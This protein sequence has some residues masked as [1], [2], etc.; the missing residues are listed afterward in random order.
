MRILMTGA[1]GLI[2]KELGKVL[3]EKGH[4]IV[5]ISR[6]LSKARENLP[7]PCEVVVGDLM[8]GPVKDAK[9]LHIDSVIN[10]MGEPVVEGRWSEEK[11]RRIYNSRV[12]GTRHL[13]QSIPEST[14]TFISS[15]A[16]GYYGDCGDE[17][18][19]EERTAG[20][21]FLARV[22]VAWEAESEKAPGRK[23]FIRTGIVLSQ[24]G[25]ALEQMMFP[26][27]AGV[28]GVLGSGKHY[29]SWIHL[30]DIVGLYVFALENTQVS[31]PL[32]GVA[33]V[34]VSN[35]ELS[36][37]LA[38]KLGKKLGPSVPTAALKVLFGEVATVMLSSMRGSTEK[39][40][41]LGYKFQYRTVDQALEEIC[42]P[43]RTGEDI[44]YSEQ[45]LPE[46]PEKIFHFFQDAYNL[47]QITP[48]TLNFHIENISTPEVQ[49]GTLIDYKLKI[50][51]VPV[52]WRTEID[53]W[54]PPHRFVDR[55]LKG[56]YRMWHHTHQFRP[57][58]GGTLMI[59]RV[60]Y[61]L[62]MGHLGWLV[63][64]K[65][66]RKDVENIFAFRKRFISTLE[67]PKKG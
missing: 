49:Q 17:I 41:S 15:S 54:Q 30:Q 45:F 43:Y 59:D 64:G 16:I 2:G 5:V 24:Q 61:R 20:S 26:F 31:G 37:V 51:G 23:V 50:R 11:K 56:P 47:E 42:E 58:C 62:P 25:G 8:D 32:N 48:P 35:R 53:E 63:A 34:P 27:R 38:S 65:W 44:F 57:F 19:T 55:Q 12:Q 40:E 14:R 33:P 29:M 66:I 18:L 46:P 1:T 13:I 60:R 67:I 52:K 22:T 21:D 6:S 28:G 36:E 10:L 9:L 39:S 3:A 7:F 4:E